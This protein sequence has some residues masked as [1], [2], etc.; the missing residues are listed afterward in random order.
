MLH[1][2][3]FLAPL[4]DTTDHIQLAVKGVLGSHFFELA[5]FLVVGSPVY[6][7]LHLVV[8]FVF[9]THLAPVFLHLLHDLLGVHVWVF[10]FE[11]AT[12]L[13]TVKNE[14]AQRSFWRSY[15][16]STSFFLYWLL[17]DKL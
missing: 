2:F 8:L 17:V 5:F 6:L 7:A 3:P 11:H 9:L 12:S 1:L 10:T 16:T 13:L 14:R 15:Y 4:L